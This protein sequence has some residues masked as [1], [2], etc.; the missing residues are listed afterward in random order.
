MHRNKKYQGETSKLAIKCYTRG[1]QL[2]LEI[3]V[4]AKRGG[5]WVNKQQSKIMGT[6]K[7]SNMVIQRVQSELEKTTP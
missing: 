6:V 7:I 2:K 1:K 3:K 5:G 4:I